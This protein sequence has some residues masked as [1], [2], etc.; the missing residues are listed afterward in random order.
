MG[1]RTRERSRTHFIAPSKPTPLEPLIASSVWGIKGFPGVLN[2]IGTLLD[3]SQ[4]I[5]QIFKKSQKMEGP[6]GPRDLGPKKH[7]N[8]VFLTT[9]K[10]CASTFCEGSTDLELQIIDMDPKVSKLCF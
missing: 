3:R 6:M 4:T 8:Q 5:K 7:E 9:W 2:I 10:R 1:G